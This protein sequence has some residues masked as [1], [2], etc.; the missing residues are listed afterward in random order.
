MGYSGTGI[1]SNRWC[2]SANSDFGHMAF[3]DHAPAVD[4]FSYNIVYNARSNSYFNDSNSAG[5]MVVED[6]ALIRSREIFKTGSMTQ[7]TNRLTILNELTSSFL[8]ISANSTWNDI[9]HEGVL[10]AASFLASAGQLITVNRLYTKNLDN[11][12]GGLFGG[13]GDVVINDS[14]IEGGNTAVLFN[15][16]GSLTLNRCDVTNAGNTS[17][18]QRGLAKGGSG[19]FDITDVHLSGTTGFDLSVVDISTVIPTD[20]Q[21]FGMTSITTP[22]STP[23]QPRTYSAISVDV[24]VAEEITFTFTTDVPAGSYVEL[25]DSNGV[26]IATSPFDAPDVFIKEIGVTI[27]TKVTD[28]GLKGQKYK[29]AHVHKMSAPADTY[30]WRIRSFD[31]ND[32]AFPSDVQA[33]IVVTGAATT[34]PTPAG[35]I[36]WETM[37]N[38]IRKRFKTQIQDLIS[39]DL[40]TQF[41][42]APFS[43]PDKTRWARVV[44]L[45]GESR[46]VELGAT[47]RHRTPGVVIVS[48]FIP[49]EQGDKEA[50]VI[51]DLIGNAFRSVSDGGVVYRTP[52]INQ[53]RRLSKEWQLNVELPFTA[54]IIQ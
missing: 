6:L 38:L 20:E 48:I 31:V 52:R 26:V 54:D 10:Q 7:T 16:A 3:I 37:A 14:I 24:S 11:L 53:I 1:N 25:I 42:N 45:P 36:N 8:S 23:N 18:A 21:H 51:A 41:D 27:K 47:T 13:I 35:G 33:S 40:P 43:K 5:S 39:P 34:A 22:K 46:Q 28:W 17:S 9:S 2:I 15:G 12:V 30:T 50:Y 19:T 29:N 32:N 44:I 4:M 49:L